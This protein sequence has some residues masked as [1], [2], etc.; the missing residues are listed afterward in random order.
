[1]QLL[2]DIQGLWKPKTDW[3]CVFVTLLP[4]NERAAG[5]TRRSARSASRPI[6]NRFEKFLVR[7][8]VEFCLLDPFRQLG[9]LPQ[10]M[11]AMRYLPF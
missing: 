10:C 5:N 2:K 4:D 3:I 6:R 9:R 8:S 11:V 1:M 7:E